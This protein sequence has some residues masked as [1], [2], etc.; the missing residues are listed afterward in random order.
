MHSH[1]PHTLAR[2]PCLD[3]E[4]HT[5]GIGIR[6]EKLRHIGHTHL[7]PGGRAALPQR[8]PEGKLLKLL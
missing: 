6:V 8:I 3:S 7:T 2:Q 1:G 4:R 5:A